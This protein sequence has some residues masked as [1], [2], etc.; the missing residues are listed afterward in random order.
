[1]KSLKPTPSRRGD[2]PAPA[3]TGRRA[4]TRRALVSSLA[5]VALLAVV[6]SSSASRTATRSLFDGQAVSPLS[7]HQAGAGREAA[8]GVRRAAA[9]AWAA[10]L[11]AAPPLQEEEPP[12]ARV[13]ETVELFAADCET[14]KSSFLLG[15]TVCARATNIPVFGTEF[16]PV[17]PLRKFSWVNSSG[18]EV[19][20]AD[21]TTSTQTS[22][23][24]IPATAAGLLGDRRGMW[25]VV[26]SS[27]YD[28]SQRASAPFTV[29]DPQNAA[30][31]LSV[32][33]TQELTLTSVPA[34]AQA[35]FLIFVE[36]K[37]PDAAANVELR[38]PVPDNATFFSFVQTEGTPFTCVNPNVSAGP[39]FTSVCTAASLPAGERAAFTAVYLVGGNVAVGSEIASDSTVTS[40]TTERHQ[41]DNSA[42]ASYKV[43]AT[44]TC[45]ITTS[46]DVVVDAA[47]GQSGAAVSYAAPTGSGNCGTITCD[48][49]SG[50]FFPLGT[51]FVTCSNAAQDVIER[52]SVTVN[53]TQAPAITCPADFT[54][55]ETAPGAGSA[56]VNYPGPTVVDNDPNVAVTFNPPSGSLLDVGTHQVTA[57]A[58]DISGNSASCSFEVTV[59]PRPGSCT[60]TPEVA[61]LPTVTGQC[62]VTVAT[63]P[64]AVDSCS[65]RVGATTNNPRS[66][67]TP[68]TYTINW[69]YTSLDGTT[70]TQPQT[71]V[72]TGGSGALGIT[73]QPVV[74]VPLA[75]GS[76]A[77]SLEIDDLGAVLNT[78]VTGSCD[79]IDITR[80][81]SPA[82]PNNVFLAGVAYTVVST[83]TSGSSS[84]SVTQTLKVVDGINPT[85]T[86]PA[87]ATYQCA[88]EVPA[89]SGTQAT[90]ADNCGA[91]NISVTETT[92]GG[93][94]SPAS[95]LVITRTF[96]ATDGGGRTASD[97]QVITVVDTTK[98]VIT[99]NGANPF[100]VE[101]HTSFTDPGATASD[102][103]D[104]SV[105]VS[106]SGS[107]DVN[108]PGTYT[109]TYTATDAAGNAATS[110]TRTVNVVDTTPPVISCPADIV[111]YLPLNTPD[112]SMPVS[113]T[114]TASDSCDSAVPV[115]YSHIPGSIFPVGTTTVSATAT[116]DS[117][118][119]SSCSF[120]VTVL[121]NFT[122]FFSP[123]SNPPTLN[124][125]NAGRA[126]P[127]KFS[128]SGNKGLGIFAVNSP[129]SQQ[130]TCDS[131]APISNLE[132]TVTA[133]GSSLSYNAPSDQYNYTWKTESAWAGTCRKL[134]V[135]LNDGSTHTALFKF[136]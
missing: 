30:V 95:P 96:T 119:A 115:V 84:A 47:A 103:C 6:S 16:F 126:V 129:A 78:S 9:P 48:L 132:E 67:D 28:S 27:I 108:T 61:T 133:G 91:V 50:T 66:F 94:G 110:V 4:H 127:V 62:A 72:V 38:S 42:A 34:G 98:P 90:A 49:P 36:N 124:L 107:V 21:I 89:A 136:K 57:T 77:C 10:P 23:F 120:N 106:V 83:V 74:N 87:D 80:T 2:G 99:L 13:E 112:V 53:D 114:V 102:N 43:S 46:Q 8:P 76:T 26:I 5:L 88:S 52:F 40:N 65:G 118:N 56:L 35:P 109:L 22:T 123:V 92:N 39:G 14:P 20:A 85:I 122:G 15:E 130:I 37:G 116:D 3:R 59:A 70:A 104:T 100:T 71:V 125:V 69:M 31:D 29:R 68:G 134:A 64:T 135:K 73:G 79:D 41:D 11:F 25:R 111:V 45:S 24:E 97:S 44:P 32:A 55:Q 105:P 113:Y 51:T 128:L 121:Y 93:A 101:C 17:I 19:Q 63:I 131:S 60:I 18:Y 54:V 81:V 1:M 75:A 86:A 82:A 58:T 33:A 7:H 117:G 12:P